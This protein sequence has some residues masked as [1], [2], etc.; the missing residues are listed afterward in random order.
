LA[1]DF[2]RCEDGLAGFVDHDAGVP[3][4]LRVDFQDDRL[5]DPDAARFERGLERRAEVDHLPIRRSKPRLHEDVALLRRGRIEQEVR[6]AFRREVESE[7]QRVTVRRADLAVLELVAPLRVRLDQ[8][9]DMVLPHKS[10]SAVSNLHRGEEVPKVDPTVGVHLEAVPLREVS[11]DARHR[12]AE[13]LDLLVVEQELA[14]AAAV[15]TEFVPEETVR[16]T[17]LQHPS[18]PRWFGIRRRLIKF[19]YPTNGGL[20]GLGLWGLGLPQ[21]RESGGFY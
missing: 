11:Q 15:R 13:D 17:L 21:P 6:D 19:H 12:A 5:R 18:P 9:D 7:V 8:A 3:G 14:L 10:E 1:R 4:G 20:G 2:R 16:T